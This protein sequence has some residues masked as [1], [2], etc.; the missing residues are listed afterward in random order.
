MEKKYTMKEFK[1]MFEKAQFKALNNI[2][3][4]Y[5]EIDKENQEKGGEARDAMFFLLNTMQNVIAYAELK[6]TLFGEE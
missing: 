6:K 2:E 5:K 1:E 4:Q 3:E